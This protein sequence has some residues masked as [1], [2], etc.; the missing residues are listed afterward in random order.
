MQK[1]APDQMP[2]EGGGGVECSVMIPL[3]GGFLAN[4]LKAT[5]TFLRRAPL[6]TSR[7]SQCVFFLHRP[8]FSLFRLVLASQF[9][10]CLIVC[11][12]VSACANHTHISYAGILLL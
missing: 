2:Y 3:I 10:A 12:Y 9:I 11:V 5:I 6:R 8:Q 7:T 1:G 4:D